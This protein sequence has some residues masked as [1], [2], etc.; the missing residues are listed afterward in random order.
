[1]LADYLLFMLYS[2]LYSVFIEQRRI[3]MMLHRNSFDLYGNVVREKVQES[4]NEEVT[5][6]MT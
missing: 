4:K 5:E 2:T 3:M 1:M 6:K